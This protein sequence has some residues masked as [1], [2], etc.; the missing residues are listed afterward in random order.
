MA[1]VVPVPRRA[2]WAAVV[3]IAVLTMLGVAGLSLFGL[4]VWQQHNVNDRFDAQNRRIE[5]DAE[6]FQRA[7]CDTIVKGRQDARALT[8]RGDLESGAVLVEVIT[9][10][11]RPIS[12]A[13]RE[14]I[15]QYQTLLSEREAKIVA[16]HEADDPD[17]AAQA[18][19]RRKERD[20]PR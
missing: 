1:D 16:E 17:C 13:M 2:V 15:D 19:L 7:I 9:N 5:A 6:T 20:K 4:G 14:L 3:S 18:A 11:G 8:Q 10:R 12:P